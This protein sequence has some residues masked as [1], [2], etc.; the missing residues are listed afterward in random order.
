MNGTSAEH[1]SQL[2][3]KY[4]S[5]P[6]PFSPL[7]RVACRSAQS[8]ND[9]T[10]QAPKKLAKTSDPYN[11]L[12]TNPDPHPHKPR[13]RSLVAPTRPKLPMVRSIVALRALRAL[14]CSRNICPA[15]TTTTTTT[16][17]PHSAFFMALLPSS[18]RR[19]GTLGARR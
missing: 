5:A 13:L 1:A 6:P 2:S 7:F 14:G 15:A 19:S 11:Q 9:L 18:A 10:T 17:Y 12:Q 8:M 3:F 4:P 16:A